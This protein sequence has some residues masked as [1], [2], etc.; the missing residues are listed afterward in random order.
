[1]TTS[2]TSVSTRADAWGWVVAVTFALFFAAPLIQR[3]VEG[4][5]VHWVTVAMYAAPALGAVL[6]LPWRDA[7][8]VPVALLVAVL[9]AICPTAM[10]AAFVA[11]DAVA[12][13]SK[14]GIAALTAG[15]FV[16]AHGSAVVLNA[17]PIVLTALYFESA[18]LMSGLAIATLVGLLSVSRRQASES[19]EAARRAE[20]DA[21]AARV[22]EARLAERELIARE[23][24]DV[25]AHRI[26]LVALHAGALARDNLSPEDAREASR[27]IQVN[28]QASLEE[29]RGML[30]SL[31]GA[32]APPAPRQ[33]TLADLD[34][35]I[36]EAE[37]AGQAV[38]L[39][40]RGDLDSLPTPVSRHLF[41]IVQEAVTN[42][43]KH[44][45]GAPVTVALE[46]RPDAFEGRI[47][48]PLA[49]LAPR[50]RSGAG[51]GLA[52]VAERVALLG[53]RETHGMHG[54]EFIL[55]VIVPL[56][57]TVR[58]KEPA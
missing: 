18:L 14:V 31:R 7:A 28:A 29:L 6:A 1:M 24:H 46:R 30:V 33:P 37:E 43:R 52:G 58:W 26:S 11:Q 36:A 5:P 23:M 22:N 25:V 27:L 4:R 53:G 54:R 34:V 40:E 51:F 2:A 9:L 42:A 21:L 48:N 39:E 55:H 38:V 44:A 12:R 16:V 20:E 3:L 32:D 35:L 56:A 47:T 41:R 49:H 45:P 10:G 50:D 17:Q 57:D 15:A 8:P 19:R 13:R